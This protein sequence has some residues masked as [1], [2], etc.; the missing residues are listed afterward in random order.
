MHRG[1]GFSMRAHHASSSIWAGKLQISLYGAVAFALLL[2]GFHQAAQAQVLFGSVV[3]NVTDA[4]GAAV[5]AATVKITESK[6]NESRTIE[7]S[8][9]GSYTISTVPAGTYQIEITRPGFRGF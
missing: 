1:R 3:G 9:S 6:T 8:E 5:P 4:S 7:T 2:Q